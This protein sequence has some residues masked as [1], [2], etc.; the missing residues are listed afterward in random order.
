YFQG[1]NYQIAYLT[2]QILEGS[3]VSSQKKNI[4]QSRKEVKP[5]KFKI[6]QIYL[7]EANTRHEAVEKFSL[8]KKENKEDR[9][10]QS[11]VTKIADDQNTGW[12]NSLK[13]QM[14]S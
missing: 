5:M 7:V 1:R 12:L 3:A 4:W 6:I 11:E 13:K 10:F 2:F 9:Y 14:G 8:A